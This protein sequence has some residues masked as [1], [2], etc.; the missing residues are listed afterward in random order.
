M[1]RYKVSYD[2]AWGKPQQS[3]SGCVTLAPELQVKGTVLALLGQ[4]RR[5]N[6][7]IEGVQGMKPLAHFFVYMVTVADR[8]KDNK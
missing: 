2:A 6:G 5:R 7:P 4:N 1:G 3:F 8:A